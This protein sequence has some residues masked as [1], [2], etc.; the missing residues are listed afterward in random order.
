M[1]HWN[2]QRG[3]LM[4]TLA[5]IAA[6]FGTA[7]R[8]ALAGDRPAQPGTPIK[9]TSASG[10][11]R[12]DEGSPPPYGHADGYGEKQGSSGMNY[13]SNYIIWDGFTDD[14]IVY[15]V[16]LACID[17]RGHESDDDGTADR[18]ELTAWGTDKVTFT[19]PGDPATTEII[20]HNPIDLVASWYL[21]GNGSNSVDVRTLAYDVF[22][23][24][25]VLNVQAATSVIV[26]AGSDEEL[27]TK[28]TASSS[29]SVGVSGSGTLTVKGDAEG[30][31]VVAVDRTQSAT[32]TWTEGADVQGSAAYAAFVMTSAP[33]TSLT[34]EIQ[35]EESMTVSAQAKSPSANTTADV[36]HHDTDNIVTGSYVTLTAGGPGTPGGDNGPA[37]GTPGGDNG[38]TPSTGSTPEGGGGSTTTGGDGSVP[39][40]PP[41]PEE[42]PE[43]PPAPP[44]EYAPPE[45]GIS[46]GG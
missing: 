41:E 1:K 30:K 33:G 12:S 40:A 13:D 35:T 36:T 18:K 5:A 20:V 38:G 34:V 27:S 6:T 28:I 26:T 21:R 8:D 43:L 44:P 39:P 32:A 25:H 29:G 3:A 10:Y 7:A 37:P 15:D 16:F 9:G 45:I 14:V 11:P 19:A 23:G 17:G 42:E 4:L 22:G 46:V 24:R 2:R 31:V